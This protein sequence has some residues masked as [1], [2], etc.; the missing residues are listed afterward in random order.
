MQIFFIVLWSAAPQ[1]R[2]KQKL[3]LMKPHVSFVIPSS[4]YVKSY[5]DKSLLD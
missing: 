3:K 1:P 2:K 4:D 5:Q